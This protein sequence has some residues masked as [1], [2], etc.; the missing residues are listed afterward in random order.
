MQKHSS[1]LLVF[2]A[3]VGGPAFH[4]GD[5]A[6]LAANLAALR[7][8]EP[9]RPVVVGGPDEGREAASALLAGAGGLFLS[10][11]GNLSSSWPGLLH[12][13][14]RWLEEARRL[15]VPAVT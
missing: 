8:V 11:G 12:Q 3:Y 2:L 14:I 4:V 9:E 13:R 6:M 15:G 10:G 1:S 5:E 7:R